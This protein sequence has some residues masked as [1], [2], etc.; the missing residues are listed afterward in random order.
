MC[1]ERKATGL[2]VL[3]SFRCDNVIC[4]ALNLQYIFVVM[5]DSDQTGRTLS[6]IRIFLWRTYHTVGFGMRRLKSLAIWSHLMGEN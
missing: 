6:L 5:E 3:T 4:V 1:T 2:F